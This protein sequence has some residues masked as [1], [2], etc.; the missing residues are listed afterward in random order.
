MVTDSLWHEVDLTAEGQIPIT[1]VVV[2]SLLRYSGLAPLVTNNKVSE[3]PT[4]FCSFVADDLPPPDMILQFWWY[5]ETHANSTYIRWC[6]AASRRWEH[7]VVVWI[8]KPQEPRSHRR[9]LRNS[10][11]PRRAVSGSLRKQITPSPFHF[12]WYHGSKAWQSWLTCADFLM[13]MVC[14]ERKLMLLSLGS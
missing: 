6:R 13:R 9:R 10:W 8:A 7:S 1:P 11:Q 14:T 5:L 12:S 2:C 4:L 3:T